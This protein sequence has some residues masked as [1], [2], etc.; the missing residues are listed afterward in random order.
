MTQQSI[1]FLAEHLR[2]CCAAYQKR[3]AAGIFLKES[4]AI[5]WFENLRCL[6]HSEPPPTHEESI[7]VLGKFCPYIMKW[8]D[9]ILVAGDASLEA[10]VLETLSVYCSVADF[11]LIQ[12][13]PETPELTSAQARRNKIKQVVTRLNGLCKGTPETVVLKKR[14]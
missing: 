1:A 13:L 10:V 9:N 14:L 3:L 6:H 12:L 7:E 4:E 11:R 5:V 8:L 2:I